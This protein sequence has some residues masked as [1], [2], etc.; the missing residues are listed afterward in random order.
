M[1]IYFKISFLICSFFISSCSSGNNSEKKFIKREKSVYVFENKNDIELSSEINYSRFAPVNQLKLKEIPISLGKIINNIEK[2]GY[3]NSD[4]LI[5]EKHFEVIDYGL[6]MKKIYFFNNGGDVPDFFSE[7][8]ATNSKFNQLKSVRLNLSMGYNGN[9]FE[10]INLDTEIPVSL[11]SSLDIADEDESRYIYQTILNKH[12][13]NI[14]NNINEYCKYLV[15]TRINFKDYW[16]ELNTERIKNN[17]Y[18]NIY[19]SEDNPKK[20]DF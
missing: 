4:E 2:K 16:L 18:F 12:V 10:E 5:N 3:K 9:K 11:I 7:I 14:R 19:K 17:T 6:T 13:L 8:Y 1:N 15:T 20:C